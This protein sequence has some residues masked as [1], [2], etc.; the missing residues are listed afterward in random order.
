ML[1]TILN[2]HSMLYLAMMVFRHQNLRQQQHLG[3]DQVE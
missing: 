3:R 2:Q 1:T